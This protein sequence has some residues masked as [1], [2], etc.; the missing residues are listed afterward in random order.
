MLELQFDGRVTRKVHDRRR[1]RLVHG[2]V[3]AS[4]FAVG[5]H[6]PAAHRVGT[7]TRVRCRPGMR[8]RTSI[9]NGPTA[10]QAAREICREDRI[11]RRISQVPADQAQRA[12]VRRLLVHLPPAAEN[13]GVHQADIDA[14]GEQRVFLEVAGLPRVAVR[15]PGGHGNITHSDSR[16]GR[17]RIRKIVYAAI[18]DDLI[19]YRRIENAGTCGKVGYSRTGRQAEKVQRGRTVGV[20]SRIVVVDHVDG[21]DKPE[22][23]HHLMHGDGHEILRARRDTVA[24]IEIP[25]E[26]GVERDLHVP[27]HARVVVGIRSRAEVR[28]G[29]AQR[30]E[31]RA[32]RVQ[33]A[34]ERPRW[35]QYGVELRGSG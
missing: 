12:E 1:E 14:I 4:V 23:V 26:S 11:V 21:A 32:V 10:R 13:G 5:G 35:R 30:H 33:V 3:R 19:G 24:A 6:E 17:R 2:H 16:N 15:L 18:V 28:R 34:T 29:N 7:A 31:I 8:A 27:F 20:G 25:G 22:A 9:P